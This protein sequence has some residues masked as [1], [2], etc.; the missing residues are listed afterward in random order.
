[1]NAL[2]KRRLIILFPIVIFAYFLTFSEDESITKTEIANAEK[3]IGLSFDDAERDSMID[4]LNEQLENYK[5]VRE[6]HLQ[7]SVMPAVLFNPIPTGFKFEEDQKPIQ[8][9]D[10][11][12][13]KLPKNIDDLAF[14]SV[15][16]LAELIKTNQI[17]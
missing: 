12:Y 13:S 6:F 4:G 15:G 11:S 7:N 14:Y 16:E 2:I 9:S 8:F 17:Y 5:V 3:L 1:M 10:Y